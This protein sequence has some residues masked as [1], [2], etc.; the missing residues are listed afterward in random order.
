MVSAMGR[1]R[2]STS[3]LGSPILSTSTLQEAN[4]NIDPRSNEQAQNERLG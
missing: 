1:L 2:L 4:G 3:M